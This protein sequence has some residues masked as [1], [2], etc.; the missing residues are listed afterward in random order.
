MKEGRSASVRGICEDYHVSR[1]N[2]DTIDGD[3][4]ISWV[5]SAGEATAPKRTPVTRMCFGFV[6]SLLAR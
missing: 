4:F 6:T 1:V 3:T 5:A 2:V